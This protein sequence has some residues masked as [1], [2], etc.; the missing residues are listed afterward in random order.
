MVSVSAAAQGVQVVANIPT[1]S[2]PPSPTF[3]L[4]SPTSEKASFTVSSPTNARSGPGTNYPWL[5]VLQKGQTYEITGTNQAGTWWQ[6]SLNG[7]PAWIMGE[8]VT[9]NAATQNVKVVANIPATPVP[10]TLLSEKDG[11]VMVYV[12]AGEFLMGSADADTEAT[13]DQKPQ[14]RVYLDAFWIDRT[15]VTNA[16]FARF[17]TETGHKTDAENLG[18]SWALNVTTKQWGQ[19]TGADWQH[20]R[21]PGSDTKGLE[22][23]PVVHVSWNDALAYCRWAGRRL[24]TEAEWEKAAHGTDGRKYPWGNQDVTSNLLNFADRNLDLSGADK[25]VD[26]GYQLTA[27]VGTYLA[28]ASPHGALDMAGNVWEWV[29]D[30]YNEKYYANSPTENPQGPD[31]GDRRVRRGGSWNAN[32]RNV[33]AAVRF[34][35]FPGDS[36]GDI[37][38]RCVRSP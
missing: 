21:G 33:R 29:A 23:H 4:P 8:I 9:A 25:S 26:D 2:L 7:Q 16:M 14:H 19:T 12:P 5:A 30:R 35:I 38:L 31:S 18:Q 3:A 37:G 32:H 22:Q 27:P 34:W 13:D 24:P 17:V 15:E 6:F 10:P 20:P 36:A 28:G 1:V 11:M